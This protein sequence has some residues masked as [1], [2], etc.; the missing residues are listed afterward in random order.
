MN[1]YDAIKN[2]L[3]DMD[4]AEL[5]S[6]HNEY[7]NATNRLDDYVYSMQEFDE[8]MQH[9]EPWEIVRSAFYGKEFRPC[10]DYFYFNGYANLESF[11][12]VGE[13][14]NAPIYT[15]EIADYITRNEDALYNDDLQE[16]ID[17]YIGID[18]ADELD[19]V[20]ATVDEMGKIFDRPDA[21]KGA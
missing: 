6:V 4:T 12:Y 13:N 11:D 3:D 1:L 18:D 17:E 2:A 16:I 9:M 15:G 5:V 19:A 14:S 8:I 20:A 10:D 21:M 7:C